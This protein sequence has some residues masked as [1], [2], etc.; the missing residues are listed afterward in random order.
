[1]SFF[2]L[3]SRV[4]ALLGG[5]KRLGVIL[6]IANI[7][8]AG[9]QFAEPVLF[10]RII[11]ALVGAQAAGR[12]PAMSDLTWLLAAWVAFGLFTIFAGVLLALYADRLAHR[13]RLA[14]ITGYFEHVIQM[15]IPYHGTVHS[16]RL[17]KVML[18]GSDAL[19]GM[20]LSFFRD[21]FA[22]FVAL[23]LLLPVA[24]WMNWRLGLLLVGLLCVFAVL[25]SYVIRR[26]ETLQHGVESYH[27]DL[28]ERASDA[29]GNVALIQ[30]FTRIDAEVHGIRDVADRLLAAQ[31]P[32]LS[33]WALAAVATRAA[34]TITIL[35]IFVVG[36]WLHLQGLTSIGEI[37]T[38][39]G[40]AT[41]FVGKL[42][43][44]VAFSNRVVLDA[45]RLVEFFGVLDAAPSVRD[46]PGAV[47][48]GHAKGEVEFDR[49]SFSYD[50]KRPAVADLSFR[51][52]PGET[53]ALVGATGAG[54]STALSLLHRVFD[55]QSGAVRID[56]HD[57]RD[58]T[59]VSVRRNIGVVFQEAL[60]FNRSI[61]ENLRVG[62]PDATQAE[63]IEACTR[64]QAW[65]FISQ[66]PD[67]LATNVGERGR[68]LSGGERQRIAIA[69][70][71]LK[72]P[73]ILILDEAT[74]SLDA[75][76]EA[77]VQAA[78]D[79]V[80]RGRTT[81]VIAHRLATVRNADR[82]LVFHEGRIVESGSFEELVH[83]RKRFAALAAAQFM[84]PMPDVSP[85]TAPTPE[86]D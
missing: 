5:E 38:F 61:E 60:V 82:I 20:W 30:S 29:L 83:L 74:S 73:P 26:T 35:T 55:P 37:V 76:T 85:A 81:F 9:A 33:W 24:V 31:I 86:V 56:G 45:P 17:M 49:V 7:A 43:Q 40:I 25:T 1:M 22:S 39:V 16:G 32:V 46:R 65:D 64:A 19:W 28:A 3:Y 80:M 12:V 51:A 54:K 66:S 13:R 27:S 4:F 8:L 48:L 84:I 72:D 23:I 62:K 75:T 70:A 41:M 18:Q 67:G 57:I 52:M 59:L 71:L 14:V 21:H 15:P 42:D 34:T 53:L 11:D 68:A 79:E 69:R 2:Q 36:T 47:D 50:G 78:L 44:A 77:A 58:L 10:G 63:L 6:A